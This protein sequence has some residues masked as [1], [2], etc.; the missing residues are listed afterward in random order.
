MERGEREISGEREE[1]GGERKEGVSYNNSVY[2]CII[3]G[4]CA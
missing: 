2:T 4:N 3:I 1:K